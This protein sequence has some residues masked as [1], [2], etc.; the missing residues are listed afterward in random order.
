MEELFKYV[1]GRNF[2]LDEGAVGRK[3]SEGQHLQDLLCGPF[4]KVTVTKLDPSP[5]LLSSY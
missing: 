3:M 4:S 1:P 2:D 5:W